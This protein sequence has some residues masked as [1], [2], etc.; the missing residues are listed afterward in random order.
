MTCHQ[1]SHPNHQILMVDPLPRHIR[2]DFRCYCPDI[3]DV[4]PS[5]VD[6]LSVT[7]A[8]KELHQMAVT[9]AINGYIC[10]K[11]LNEHPP[12]ISDSETLLPRQTRSLLAQLRAG[13]CSF[14]NCYRER[15]VPGTLNRCPDCLQSPH[16]TVHL[17]NCPNRPTH[18]RPVDLWLRPIEVAQSLQLPI[19]TDG[20]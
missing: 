11:V 16:D 9:E 17:F 10:N 6:R 18:L 14:L 15:I 5:D 4:I 19:P 2:K 12:A 3:Q 1:R 13:W 20:T 8:Q 7:N